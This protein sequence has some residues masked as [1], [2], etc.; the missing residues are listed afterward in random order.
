MRLPAGPIEIR[1]SKPLSSPKSNGARQRNLEQRSHGAVRRRRPGTP[2]LCTP[3]AQ[4]SHRRAVPPVLSHAKTLRPLKSAFWGAQKLGGGV[5]ELSVCACGE[6]FG[7]SGWGIGQERGREQRKREGRGGIGESCCTS[8]RSVEGN[9][10]G[11]NFSDN[12]H[13]LMDIHS[14]QDTF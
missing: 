7:T 6:H 2:L 11:D 9:A 8:G 10:G 1:G 3:L 4:T 5:G 12:T 13:L 14:P